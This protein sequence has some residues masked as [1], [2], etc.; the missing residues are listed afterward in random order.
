MP[1]LR[2][3]LVRVVADPQLAP[4]N[5]EYQLGLASLSGYNLLDKRFVRLYCALLGVPY[6]PAV[7]SISLDPGA[8][9]FPK[10]AALY[11]IAAR[12]RFDRSG[13][14]GADL[15]S[16]L[17]RLPARGSAIWFSERLAARRSY[18]EL[19]A[20]LAPDTLRRVALF[21]ATDRQAS[22]LPDSVCN[23]PE[24][25]VAYSVGAGPVLLQAR[26][27]AKRQ[28][29]CP[30]TVSMNY[31]SDMTASGCSARGWRPL[32]T[33]PAYG[34]LLG[35]LVPEDIDEIRVALY[36]RLSAG[37]RA[38]PWLGGLLLLT[39]LVNAAR[40]RRANMK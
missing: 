38:S 36:A 35:V 26:L 3:P 1:E 13:R 4:N 2:S 15:A 22:G 10:A 32:R 31:A 5:R 28:G 29:L 17:E 39:L 20:S 14:E 37:S 18:P 19:V 34:A 23:V 40:A 33:F 12:L 16:R 11:N 7:S 8:A 25:E 21:V 27:P 24:S 30:L 9:Y 6:Q